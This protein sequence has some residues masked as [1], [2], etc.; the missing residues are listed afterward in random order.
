MTALL[1]D[2]HVWIWLAGGE[3]RL[4]KQAPRFNRVAANGQLLL[5]AVSMYETALI[6]IETEKGSRRG[7]QAVTISAAGGVVRS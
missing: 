7:K 5:S 1:L 6:G 4:A 3:L 2:T